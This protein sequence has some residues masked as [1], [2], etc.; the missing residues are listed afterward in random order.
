[1]RRVMTKARWLWLLGALAVASCKDDVQPPGP[2]GSGLKSCLEQPT[3][4][5]RPPSGQLPCELLPPGF[6]R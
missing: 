2:E 5:A 3:A 4:L 1:M 6:S